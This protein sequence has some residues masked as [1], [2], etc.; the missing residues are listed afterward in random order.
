MKEREE[1]PPRPSAL[2]P[3]LPPDSDLE[4]ICCL[5]CLHRDP[6]QRLQSAGELAAML[7]SVVRRERVR[8]A[9]TWRQW[10]TRVLPW[11]PTGLRPPAEEVKYPQRWKRCLRIEAVTSLVA[12]IGVFLLAFAAAPGWPCG[13]GSWSPTQLPGGSSGSPLP[14]A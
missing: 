13:R 11:P 2:N 7:R 4:W 6:G 8:D 5:R 1:L 14:G 9:E 10:V 3:H 12:H